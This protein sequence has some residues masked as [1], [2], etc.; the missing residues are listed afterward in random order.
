MGSGSAPGD[1]TVGQVKS[2]L[3][4]NHIDDGENEATLSTFS[5]FS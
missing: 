5:T 2:L 3:A 4:H 1:V